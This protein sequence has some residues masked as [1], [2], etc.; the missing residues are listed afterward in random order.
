MLLKAKRW[1]IKAIGDQILRFCKK[2]MYQY[3]VVC[4]KVLKLTLDENSMLASC[5]KVGKQD[6]DDE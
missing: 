4:V 1:A 6:K 2:V 3:L 5:T